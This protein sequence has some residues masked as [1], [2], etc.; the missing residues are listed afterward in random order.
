VLTSDGPPTDDGRRTLALGFVALA[1]LITTYVALGP[2]LSERIRFSTSASGLNQ[3]RGGDLAA[4]CVVV[5]ACLAV[6]WL[7]R[8]GHPAGPVL[9]LAPATFAMYTYSQ[10]A[11]GNEYL[12]RPG[13]LERWF[14]LL[15][16]LF[17]LA[18]A[19]AVTCWATSPASSLPPTS[20]R[21]ERGSGVLLL[22]MA[23]FV[24]V[25]LHLPSFVDALRSPAE[26][27]AYLATP[28]TFWVVK[29]YDLGI[30][31]PAAVAVGVGLLRRRAWARKPAYAILGGYVLLAWSVA[32]M[33]WTMAANDDPDAS[34]VISLVMTALAGAGTVFAFFLYRPLFD[35]NTDAAQPLGDTSVPAQVSGDRQPAAPA[36]SPS[37]R[38]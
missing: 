28:N 16:A 15:L 20:R 30:V 4:L 38:G 3:I 6:A 12:D 19:L 7:I 23:F 14:L 9:G 5:P 29:F 26:G 21:L 37:A 22:V 25:G 2:L 32:G 8:R 11:L 34:L 17:V 1:A 33:T 27:A 36:S 13:N 18:A 31:V 10:L 24:V 35:W